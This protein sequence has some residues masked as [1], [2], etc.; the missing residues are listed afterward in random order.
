MINKQHPFLTGGMT[1]LGSSSV[2]Y[3]GNVLHINS[4]LSNLT[5]GVYAELS[6][7]THEQ[8]NRVKQDLDRLKFLEKENAELK[9]KSVNVSG[10]N[11]Q[12]QDGGKPKI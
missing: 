12:A 9:S 8:S 3:A 6:P 1:L 7:E 4:Y 2:E 5:N 11:G 10:R